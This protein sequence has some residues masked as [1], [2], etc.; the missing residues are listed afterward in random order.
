MDD[1]E[2]IIISTYILL[3]RRY[4]RKLERKARKKRSQWVRPIYQ[5]REESGIYHTLV[6]EMALGEREFY[7]K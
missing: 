4:R 7:F 5:Q 1:D 3:K 6:Q 2:A